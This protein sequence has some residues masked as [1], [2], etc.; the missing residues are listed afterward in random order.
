MILFEWFSGFCENVACWMLTL[1]AMLTINA[2]TQM[3][4]LLWLR[5]IFLKIWDDSVVNKRLS[6]RASIFISFHLRFSWIVNV[7]LW[8]WAWGCS[9]DPGSGM[10]RRKKLKT[11]W[12]MIIKN[13]WHVSVDIMKTIWNFRLHCRD[14]SFL[15]ISEHNATNKD[16]YFGIKIIFTEQ[17]EHLLCNWESREW[18]HPKIIKGKRL[19]WLLFWFSW[20][21]YLMLSVH[22]V[23]LLINLHKRLDCFRCKA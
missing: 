22:N 6:L 11:T 12:G 4:V 5:S 8:S 19:V 13:A 17:K 15:W 3:L 1:N 21:S 23:M 9:H 7:A 20:P 16:Q 18:K 10:A 2:V 14:R